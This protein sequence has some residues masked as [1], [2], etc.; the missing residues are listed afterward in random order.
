[1]DCYQRLEAVFR[2]RPRWA[3]PSRSHMLASV[4]RP[5]GGSPSSL[6][7]QSH[8]E[9]GVVL[10]GR[11]HHA[12]PSLRQGITRGIATRACM[13]WRH[14]RILSATLLQPGCHQADGPRRYS[15]RRNPRN[16]C[17]LDG[18]VSQQQDP[19]GCGATVLLSIPHLSVRPLVPSSLI[20]SFILLSVCSGQAPASRLR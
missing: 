17:A 15:S 19:T 12:P 18:L 7:Q 5:G 3:P 2:R 13:C 8:V 14:L 20:H 4:P 16:S 1:M 10:D 6:S 9:A 11:A